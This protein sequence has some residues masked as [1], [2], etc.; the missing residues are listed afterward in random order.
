MPA[1]QSPPS[2]QPKEVLQVSAGNP[3]E[4][5]PDIA[6]GMVISS[7]CEDRMVPTMSTQYMQVWSTCNHCHMHAQYIDASSFFMLLN[8]ALHDVSLTVRW[9]GHDVGAD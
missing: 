4:C 7:P 1:Q 5:F 9:A 8:A 6:Q 3:N 2:R